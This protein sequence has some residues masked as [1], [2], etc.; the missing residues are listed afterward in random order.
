MRGFAGLMIC[1]GLIVTCAMP[2]WADSLEWHSPYETTLPAPHPPV[3]NANYNSF[4]AA[5]VYIYPAYNVLPSYASSA[6]VSGAIPSYASSAPVSGAIPSYA[7]SA[8]IG[9]V[10][11]YGN[12][13]P[14]YASPAY[15]PAFVTFPTYGGYG[16]GYGGAAYA[17]SA[18]RG[19]WAGGGQRRR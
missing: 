3:Y 14:A 1:I 4:I 7:S 19:T 16:Y 15:T 2:S 17:R 5:P 13:I 12:F 11:P 8:P 10:I 9:G 18:R 6:P